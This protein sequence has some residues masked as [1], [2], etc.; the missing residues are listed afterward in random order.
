MAKDDVIA[1]TSSRERPA[2]NMSGFAMLFALLMVIA[3][4]VA[5]VVNLSNNARRGTL[6]DAIARMSFR[7]DL[8]ALGARPDLRQRQCPLQDLQAGGSEFRS[9]A[10]VGTH[11]RR[12]TGTQK[13]AAG[14]PS[15]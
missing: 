10:I 11:G 5:G 3:L 4:Q 1:L 15:S 12:L 9:V 7:S 2:S 8:P 6:L 14:L 13:H